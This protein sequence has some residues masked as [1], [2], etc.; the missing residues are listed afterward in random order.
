MLWMNHSEIVSQGLKRMKSKTCYLCSE[1]V[2]VDRFFHWLS[3]LLIPIAV[4]KKSSQFDFKTMTL[5][6][7][8]HF[9]LSLIKI[10]NTFRRE[11]TSAAAVIPLKLVLIG[12]MGKRL[13][14]FTSFSIVAVFSSLLS[15][16]LF[17]APVSSFFLKSSNMEEGTVPLKYSWLSMSTRIEIYQ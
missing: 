6:T 1:K 14:P 11:A 16:S 12:G 10:Q 3:V 4:K 13:S 8:L 2:E 7:L 17:C 9:K 15:F 5:I